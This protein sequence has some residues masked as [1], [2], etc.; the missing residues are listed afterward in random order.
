MSETDNPAGGQAAV[1]LTIEAAIAAVAREF[2]M[3]PG[4]LK[5]SMSE[6]SSRVTIALT[7][8]TD[9]FVV[10]TIEQAR[11][12][13]I[14]EITGSILEDTLLEDL[15]E[16]TQPE[17]LV[18]LL[19]QADLKDLDPWIVSSTRRIVQDVARDDRDAFWNLWAESK[20]KPTVPLE[21]RDF[22]YPSFT[23]VKDLQDHLVRFNCGDKA[24][25]L[26]DLCD[27]D[28]EAACEVLLEQCHLDGGKAAAAFL[29]E[30]DKDFFGGQVTPEGFVIEND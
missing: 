21:G 28:H 7:D 10:R 11:L 12:D 29:Q 30:H 9:R 23:M 4:S 22:V 2:N 18:V 17:I 8:S 13:R 24:R 6:D 26:M 19:G 5:G 15:Y 25:G 20:L 27:G 3:V 14:K 16:I 1:P